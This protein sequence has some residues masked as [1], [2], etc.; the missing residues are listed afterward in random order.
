MQQIDSLL[1]KEEYTEAERIIEGYLR[2]TL[3]ITTF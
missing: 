1:A 3:M 2:F